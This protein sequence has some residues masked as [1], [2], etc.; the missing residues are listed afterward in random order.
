MVEGIPELYPA[1]GWLQ[2]RLQPGCRAMDAAAQQDPW[3]LFGGAAISALIR[4]A[5]STE[6][7]RDETVFAPEGWSE[8]HLSAADQGF[9]PESAKEAVQRKVLRYGRQTADGRVVEVRVLG[10]APSSTRKVASYV[11]KARCPSLLFG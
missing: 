10:D 9:P 4:A 11:P 8:C 2:Q 7:V 1:P 6:V 5:A 3:H